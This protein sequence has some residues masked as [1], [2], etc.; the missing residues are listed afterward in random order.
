MQRGVVVFK[1]LLSGGF[2]GLVVGG[3][4]LTALSLASEQPAGNEPPVQPQLTAPQTTQAPVESAEPDM[5][6]SE[7][8][9]APEQTPRAI[10][11]QLE[12]T[13]PVTDVEPAQ[14]PQTGEV[15]A[16]MIAPDPIEIAP[17]IEAANEV[18]V[19]PNPQSVAPQVPV[20]EDD[21][22]LSTEP[23]P[24]PLVIKDDVP[25]VDIAVPVP[26]APKVGVPEEIA[27]AVPELVA[28]EPTSNLPVG[29]GAVKV[30]RLVG[31]PE[32]EVVETTAV[33]VPDDAPALLR[34]GTEF[35]NFEAKPLLS[36]VLID[37]GS[38]GGAVPALSAL[39]FPVTVV[40]DPSKPDAAAKMAEY[41]SA[42]IEVG[43]LAALPQGASAGDVE[44]A[45]E[46]TFATLPE[47]VLMLD[48]GDG[49]FQTDRSVANQA[50][51]FLAA[52]GR[53]F[54]SVASGL[55]MAW[56]AAES[57]DVPALGIFR[58]LDSEGQ[59][60]RVIRRF[61]DQAAFRA[62]QE[63]GV[64]LLAR[65]RPDTISALILWG[66]ANRAGQVALA[67]LSAALLAQ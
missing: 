45:F 43:V 52:E 3:A 64:V 51:A 38:M 16:D 24:V 13:Q 18:P 44:V 54:V 17:E 19:L 56:R 28:P 55:N 57:A 32:R 42:G 37:D 30:N 31:D 47:S 10:A 2:W 22:A 12:V 63:S 7:G 66:T 14:V 1:G 40:L 61:M 27:I 67:P 41:R 23:A 59:D 4:S 35:E 9:V 15:V 21:L 34:Y 6:A 25:T 60:A 20:G 65:V 62:R 5:A 33:E 8:A 11:P 58:D 36:V 46:A 29:N 48:M 50:M 26:V 53:G 39:P 49:G